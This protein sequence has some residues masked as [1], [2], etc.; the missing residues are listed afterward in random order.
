LSLVNNAAHAK[1]NKLVRYLN[2]VT[3]DTDDSKEGMYLENDVVI[4]ILTGNY[5]RLEHYA[6]AYYS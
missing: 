1:F 5:K 2:G 3:D 4:K 6:I